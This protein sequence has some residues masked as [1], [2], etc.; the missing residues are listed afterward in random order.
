MRRRRPAVIAEVYSRKGARAERKIC[1]K[2]CHHFLC[3]DCAC[4]KKKEREGR[5]FRV[6]REDPEAGWARFLLLCDAVTHRP[7]SPPF[8]LPLLFLSPSKAA[9]RRSGGESFLQG[10]GGGGRFHIRLPFA[11]YCV[12]AWRKR[13]LAWEME[14]ESF[15]QTECFPPHLSQSVFGY[16]G[17]LRMRGLLGGN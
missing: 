10:G 17:I 1:L 12:R 14:G 9:R 4:I 6:S 16:R 15:A 13:P 11:L 7:H 2:N 8:T 5:I 3:P